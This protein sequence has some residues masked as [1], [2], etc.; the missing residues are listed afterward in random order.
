MRILK[1]RD[2]SD[3]KSRFQQ[4]R[5][6]ETHR[7]Q[8]RAKQKIFHMRRREE[9]FAL[10][11]D[12]CLNCGFSDRRALQIDHV[13]GGGIKERKSLN[14]KDFHSL[15]LRTVKSKEIKY[16]LLCANCNWIKRHECQEWG[17]APK[18]T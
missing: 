15:V 11:G 14:T 10:M 6:R 4:K 18:R 8:I 12:K 7:E 9:L 3:P 1:K 17:G 16:Q 2:R 5:Y 13:N